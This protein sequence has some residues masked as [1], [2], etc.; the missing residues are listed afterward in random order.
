MKRVVIIIEEGMVRE[1]FGNDIKYALIDWDSHSVG[2]KSCVAGVK[3]TPMKHLTDPKVRK[4]LKEE[5][6]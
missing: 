3:A 4:L 1:V 2:D 5:G 6:W